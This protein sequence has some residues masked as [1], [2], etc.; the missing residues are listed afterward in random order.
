[1]PPTRWRIHFNGYF[2]FWVPLGYRYENVKG[3]PGKMI[4]RDEPNASVIQEALE[5]F[6]T[7]RFETQAEVKRFLEQ[8]TIFKRDL[9]GE[10]HPQRI[11]NLLT[12]LIYAGYYKYEPWGVPLT[13]GKHEA[14][15]SWE[16]MLQQRVQRAAQGHQP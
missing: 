8:H 15:I 3:H 9:N 5:G 14:L 11:K 10:I 13:K 12:N 6:A 16:R 7:G 4:V 2:A 1:M